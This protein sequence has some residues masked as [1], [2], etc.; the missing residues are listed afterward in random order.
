[1]RFLVTSSDPARWAAFADRLYSVYP[2]E[3]TLVVAGAPHT[4]VQLAGGRQHDLIFMLHPGPQPSAA[5]EAALGQLLIQGSVPIVIV[6]RLYPYPRTALPVYT[7][8]DEGIDGTALK[9]V[10][11]EYR[12]R[13]PVVSLRE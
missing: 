13:Q 2:D 8:R 1:M 3:D 9:S 10:I 11:E 12:F 5:L 4:A 6:S 7:I